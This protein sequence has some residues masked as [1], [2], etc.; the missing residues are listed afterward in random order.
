MRAS[1]LKFVLYQYKVAVIQRLAITDCILA[2]SGAVVLSVSVEFFVVVDFSFLMEAWIMSNISY[3]Q[4]L[5][6]VVL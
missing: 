4:T 6:S 2:L 3:V 5:V 1:L